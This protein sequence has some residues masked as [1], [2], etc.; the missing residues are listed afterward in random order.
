[1]VEF[2]DA[3]QVT[4]N[5]IRKLYERTKPA[6]SFKASLKED[7][8]AW[9]KELKDKVLEL[10]GDFPQPCL[11][12]LLHRHLRWLDLGLRKIASEG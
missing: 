12:L 5:F 2:I 7:F 8:L 3:P 10:L 1:M 6:L 4:D 11:Q 9:K